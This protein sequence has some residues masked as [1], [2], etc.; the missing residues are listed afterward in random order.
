MTMTRATL[1]DILPLAAA[2]GMRTFS[3][4]TALVA[5]DAPRL[6]PAMGLIAGAELVADKMPWIGNR[7][8]AAPLVGRAVIGALLGAFVA[9]RNDDHPA[10]GAA[11]GASIAVVSA[12]AGAR[13][14]RGL[15][16]PPIARGL[17][18]D[19]LVVAVGALFM[20]DRR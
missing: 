2:T 17:L 16:G 12:H 20:R 15:P 6:A 8:D 9:H 11:I 18:E 1:A 13:I 14:R 4:P 3:G 19:A 7:T 10:A 5:R